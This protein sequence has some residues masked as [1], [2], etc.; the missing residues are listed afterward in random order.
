MSGRTIPEFWKDF[1]RLAKERAERGSPLMPTGIKFID[2]ATDGLVKGKIWTI[3]GRTGA[4]KTSLALQ[5]SRNIADTG[6]KVL[7]IS[8]EMKGEELVSRM[9]CEMTRT[10]NHTLRAGINPQKD[11]LFTSFLNTIDFEVVEYGFTYQEI[12]KAIRDYY[13]DNRPDL[14]VIDFVQFIDSKGYGYDERMALQEYMRQLAELA[15]KDNIACL[16]VSQFRRPPSG[17]DLNRAP[18]VQDLKGT[19]SLEQ[20]SSVCIIIYQFADENGEHYVLKVAKNRSGP[21]CEKE[22]HFNGAEF[23][24]E[25]VF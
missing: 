16:V 12:E 6:K 5:F 19:G 10:Q 2:E 9:F 3:A 11:E 21:L 8:L 20:L 14:I 24:F 15:K 18:S 23:R 25:E 17:A 22:V 7:F 1:K 4:G 13:P